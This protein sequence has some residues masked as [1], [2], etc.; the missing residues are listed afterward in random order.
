MHVLPVT[1][2]HVM[3]LQPWADFIGDP[4]MTSRKNPMNLTSIILLDPPV[5]WMKK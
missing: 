2:K 3:G 4:A 1:G 5:L